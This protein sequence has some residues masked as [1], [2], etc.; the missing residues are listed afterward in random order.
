MAFEQEDLCGQDATSAE[1][2]HCAGV[3]GDACDHVGIHDGLQLR[4]TDAG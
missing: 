1:L 3:I 4:R 2:G